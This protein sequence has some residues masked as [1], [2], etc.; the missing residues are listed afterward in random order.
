LFDVFV[1]TTRIPSFSFSSSLG[2]GRRRR[3]DEP[4]EPGVTD[5]LFALAALC[6]LV[7][8]GEPPRDPP[9]RPRG[10]AHAPLP[11]D[12]L[13]LPRDGLLFRQD[14]ERRGVEDVAP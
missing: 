7:V 11:M 4:G 3:R 14:D 5:A 6:E 9:E 12:S 1:F 13:P 2:R 10:S 8:R